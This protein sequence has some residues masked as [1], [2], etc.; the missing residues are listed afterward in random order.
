M[1]KSPSDTKAP[2]NIVYPF[3]LI[4]NSFAFF[5]VALSFPGLTKKMF[6][7]NCTPWIGLWVPWGGNLVC[8]KRFIPLHKL[9]LYSSRKLK[10]LTLISTKCAHCNRL[11][12]PAVTNK[13]T[14]ST[15]QHNTGL[16]L[17]TVGGLEVLLY[18][19]LVLTP[20]TRLWNG[21]YL[22]IAGSL[23]EG[24]RESSRGSHINI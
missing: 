14:V 10:Y 20:R 11:G 15:A 1:H 9:C 13:P 16:F 19:A 8:K 22:K 7:E 3:Y 6:E 12:Y 2:T 4:P 17:S 23:M 21:H 18:V 24:G 5:K